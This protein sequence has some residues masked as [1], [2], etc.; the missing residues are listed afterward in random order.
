MTNACMSSP[1]IRGEGDIHMNK[2]YVVITPARNE[3]QCL[4]RTIESLLTQTALPERWVIVSD[5]STDGT[6][7]IVEEYSRK[8]GF[9]RLV[10]VR[11]D[12]K[13]D[14][15][16]KVNA[17]N[18]GLAS[19]ECDDYGF[20]ANLDADVS[21]P[22]DYYERVLNAFQRNPG[23]GVA[24]GVIL[25]RNG[26]RYSERFSNHYGIAGAVQVFARQCY[27]DIG[28]YIPLKYGG[29]DAAS[30]YIAR[31]H[32]WKIETLPELGVIHHRPR[33]NSLAFAF[34]MG[35][36]EY[37][38]GSHPLFQLIKSAYR[39]LERPYV[40]GGICRLGGY[41]WAGLKHEQRV[42]EPVRRYIGREQ[43]RRVLERTGLR[44]YFAPHPAGPPLEG[45]PRENPPVSFVRDVSREE[46]P[47]WVRVK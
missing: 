20:I 13:R 29:E 46:E 14:F 16:S 43:L 17:F 10:R 26:N 21:L 33:R 27:E 3:E 4:A 15:S 28:G 34:Q 19:V 47:P 7:R 39:M 12:Q 25:E 23:L 30:Q 5:N 8:A 31:M 38:Y 36:E 32:G 1:I 37:T 24:G 11:N 9:M 41:V 2:K 45:S 18:I 44:R 35:A 40:I 22:E 6:D 42:P